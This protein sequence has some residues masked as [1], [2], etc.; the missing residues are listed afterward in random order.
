MLQRRSAVLSV[1]TVIVVLVLVG[2]DAESNPTTTTA[3]TPPVATTSLPSETT[4]TTADVG[5]R[6]VVSGL[7]VEPGDYVTTGFEA[8]TVM[9]RVYR[10]H[11]LRMFQSSRVTGFENVTNDASA[12]DYR[13][14]AVHGF[15][16]RLSPEEV[17]AELE[18]IDQI[19]LGDTTF[20]EVGGLPGRRIEVDV[21]RRVSLW[22]TLSPSG[23][24][25]IRDW[26]VQVGPLEI[27]ILTTPAGTLFITIAA[28][29]EEWDEFLPLAEEILA[30][31]SFPDFE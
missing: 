3:T 16:F 6:P 20:V 8:T 30:G 9:Y 10:S 15:W 11:L 24:D 26:P 23:S 25:L 28:P 17:L 27:I 5:P 29:A 31:I 18:R 21:V 22:G 1:A 13:G 2:C 14:V 19:E 12:S 7:L 4:P